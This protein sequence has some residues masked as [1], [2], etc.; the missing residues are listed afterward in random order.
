MLPLLAGAEEHWA[1]LPPT[2]PEIVEK[3][4]E[5]PIDTLLGNARTSSSLKPAEQAPPQLWIQRAA[6]SLTGLPATSHQ[7]RRIRADPSEATWKTLIE[8]LL[9]S[10]AYGE[11]WAR[12]WMDVARYADTQGYVLANRD[13]RYPFAYT[14]RNWL[15]DAFNKDMPYPD[16]IKLQLAADL[17]RDKPDHPDL[18]ALGFLTVG[19]RAGNLEM[20]DDRVDVVTR[21]FLASTVACARC[22][23]HKF[24]PITMDDYYS[25]YS[26]LENTTEP[27]EKPVIGKPTDQP[28][29]QAYREKA[30]EIEALRQN[31]RRKVI[32]QLHDPSDLATYLDLAH[33]AISENWDEGKAAAEGFERG[34]FRAKAVMKWKQFFI[35]EAS[36]P[37]LA[38]WNEQMKS[39]SSAERL[40]LCR[41][42]ADEWLS[43]ADSTPL[44]VLAKKPACPL[45][46][47]ARRIPD[48]FD[49]KD[50]N[51]DAKQRSA[52]AALQIDHPGSPPRAMS[53]ADRKTGL[54][55]RSTSAATLRTAP[56]PSNASGCPFSVEENFRREKA[57]VSPL[58]KKSPIPRIR[59]PP[60]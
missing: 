3:S 24:D 44:S 16:F 37:R 42:L 36:D 7:I 32:S 12:H 39:A 48:L 22:H 47:E 49:T 60:E 14:Y 30:A 35:K 41:A 6:Y 33:L 46:Y 43:A 8:E 58:P 11:R 59:S 34:R 5:N 21:G 51:E 28:A 1:Y 54:L 17:I 15:I 52:L 45:S 13:N 29:F 38:G 9:A 50:K 19:P 40:T 57:R 23:K 26:I 18:A 20:I 56:N 10:P 27:D 4:D 31:I 25:I 2:K 53:L 55:P